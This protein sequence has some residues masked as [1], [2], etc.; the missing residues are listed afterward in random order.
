M[1]R[2][3]LSLLGWVFQHKGKGR[4]QLAQKRR[5][6]R[7]ETGL[8]LARRGGPLDRRMNVG[9]ACVAAGRS[10]QQLPDPDPARRGRQRRPRALDGHGDASGDHDHRGDEKEND[11]MRAGVER[12]GIADVSHLT[13]AAELPA[14]ARTLS[15][16]AG[17][18]GR[19]LDALVPPVS[20]RAVSGKNKG[21]DSSG[22]SNNSTRRG[23]FRLPH[24]VIKARQCGAL[25]S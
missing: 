20:P 5:K 21:R 6:N 13:T 17:K 1:I 24:A 8:Q 11:D 10:L 25:L 4:R 3:H 2:D 18:T 12:M 23:A 14:S 19:A 15:L 9:W 7:R 22:N 16:P